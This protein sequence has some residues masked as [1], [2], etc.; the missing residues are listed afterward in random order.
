[1]QY[2]IFTYQIS[3]Q[4][5]TLFLLL[6]H[7]QLLAKMTI[8][9][10]QCQPVPWSLQAQRNFQFLQL[11]KKYRRVCHKEVHVSNII[12][13]LQQ[14]LFSCWPESEHNVYFPNPFCIV[15]E[16]LRRLRI[17]C[18]QS[19]EEDDKERVEACPPL[20]FMEH[21]RCTTDKCPYMHVNVQD[22]NDNL[23]LVNY[24]WQHKMHPSFNKSVLFHLSY[25]KAMPRF[26]STHDTWIDF[27]HNDQE[28]IEKAYC[29]CQ[30][31]YTFKYLPVV[32][33]SL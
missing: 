28:S 31:S 3:C 8:F 5:Q 12:H 1:M 15:H 24:L 14:L 23:W 25:Y 2:A 11:S 26:N 4:Y 30:S 6:N 19:G 9:P 29:R 16:S 21:T 22:A 32:F 20:C 13:Q 33:F 27:P 7:Y 18:V 10:P 17:P